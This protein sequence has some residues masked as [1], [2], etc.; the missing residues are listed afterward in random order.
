LRRGIREQFKAGDG[1]CALGGR[2]RSEQRLDAAR[3]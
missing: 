1:A 2:K 3:I